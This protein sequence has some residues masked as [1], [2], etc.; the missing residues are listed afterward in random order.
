MEDYIE[1][2]EIYTIDSQEY[3]VIS[4]TKKQENT[5]ELY[6]ILSSYALQKLNCMN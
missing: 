1:T 4:R 6:N 3:T 2:K 5:D